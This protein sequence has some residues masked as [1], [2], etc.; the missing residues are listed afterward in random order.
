MRC[1]LPAGSV[2]LNRLESLGDYEGRMMNEEGRGGGR[3]M[4]NAEWKIAVAAEV[5]QLVFAMPRKP[6][7]APAQGSEDR[8][9]WGSARGL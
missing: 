2:K 6:L 4:E 3:H 1:G 7:I 8:I 9:G 5:R